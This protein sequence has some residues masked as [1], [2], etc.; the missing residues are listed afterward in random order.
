MKRKSKIIGSIAI[1]VI[2]VVFL[3][4]GYFAKKT[5]EKVQ[6]NNESMFVEEGKSSSK[7]ASEIT[8]Y[9]NGAVK[10]P[11]VYKLPS[12]S[13]VDD[14]MR[15]CGGFADDADSSKLNLAKKLKDEEHVHVDVKRNNV[16]GPG[17]PVSSGMS[18]DGKV[19][20]NRATKEELKTVP[21]I[22]DVTAQK[23]LDYRDKNNGFTNVDE[24][25][26]I[27]RIGEKTFDKIKD[28]FDI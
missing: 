23:I 26:K 11:G 28:K 19:N 5:P 10:K 16:Q 8:V 15:S 14:L 2:F 13:R 24:L 9:I 4:I 3:S 12:S 27:D 6:M 25:K 17:T 22:G 7:N 1:L 18:S 20:L 21:G